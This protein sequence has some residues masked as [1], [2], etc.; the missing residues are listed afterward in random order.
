MRFSQASWRIERRKAAA[1]LLELDGAHGEFLRLLRRQ[2]R[3]LGGDRRR[4]LLQAVLAHRLGE[5]GVGFAEGIDAVDQVDVELA[6][7]HREL[8]HAVDQGG[9]G[10]RLASPSSAF[11]DQLLGLLRQVERG[12][13]VL[14]HGLLILLVEFGILV[15]DDL[16]HANLRQLLRHQFLVEQA[17]LDGGLVLHEGG[18]HLVQVL[19]ADARRFLALRLGQA[20][21]LDLELPRLLVEADIALVRVVAALAVVEARRRAAVRVLRREL[22]ARRKHLLH[23]QARGDGLQRV[24][25]RLGDGLLGRRPARR[26]GW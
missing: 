19:L 23:Q 21:D 4:D 15:L 18:D 16:A 7:V 17:A 22:E 11:G 12:D 9:V 3:A 14:A 25:D 6:H 1:L 24:V 5:D 26:S 2:A 13:G 10:A 20:L 8:A